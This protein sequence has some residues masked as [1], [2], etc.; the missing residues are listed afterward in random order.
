MKRLLATTSSLLLAAAC[1]GR[2]PAPAAGRAPVDTA[3]AGAPAASAASAASA[4]SELARR[5][6]FYEA[7]VAASPQHYPSMAQLAMAQLDMAKETGDPAW[8]ARARAQVKRSTE[9]QPSFQALKAAA[10]IASYSHHFAEALALARQALVVYPPDTAV[11]ALEV[12][13]QLGLGEPAAAELILSRFPRDD[14]HWCFAN[15]LVMQALRRFDA[16]AAFYELA[17]S[18]AAAEGVTEL[19]RF[20]LVSAAGAYLDGGDPDRAVPYLLMAEA[21]PPMRSL[22]GLRDRRRAIHLIEWLETT[23]K[24]AEALAGLEELLAERDEPDLHRHAARLARALVAERRLTDP[25]IAARHFAAARA[26]Y[27][28][29]LDAGEIYAL[30]GL[31]LLLTEAG[32]EPALAL[33][34]AQRNLEHKR[35]AS[36]QAALKRAQAASSS[37]SSSPSSPPSA[38]PALR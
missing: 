25:A 28:R 5:L 9:I 13:A 27:Q 1:A 17:A 35:D 7:K 12:E 3:A 34:L 22:D 19:R 6:A 18:R 4:G 11:L 8:L 20:A 30:E 15:G 2:A 26:G 29:V 31:S 10:A 24:P 16:S 37:P 32:V 21:V 23:G 33:E 14:F 36:A 38:G